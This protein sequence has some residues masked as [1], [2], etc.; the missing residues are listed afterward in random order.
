[1]KI[2]LVVTDSRGK[3][4]VFVSDTLRAYSLEEA[5]GLAENGKLEGI[6]PV[7]RASGVYLRTKPSV[8]AKEHLE[9]LS[10]SAHKLYASADNL[11]SVLSTDAFRTYWRLYQDSLDKAEPN[12]VID[13]H[14]RVA[15]ETVKEKL[16]PHRNL[17]FEAAKKF[18][19][20]SYLLGAIIID[21]IARL[22]PFEEIAD[23]LAVN[24]IGANT[25]AG[26]AQVKMDTARGLIKDGY[27]NPDPH[28][29]KL[30]AA[31]IKK[32]S[33]SYLYDYVKEPEHSIFFAAARMRSLIDE[34]KRSID[35]SQ[36]PEIIATLYHLP[37]IDPHAHPQPNDRGL[38]IANEFY[39]LAR[40][41]LLP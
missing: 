28:D 16:Q 9:R 1:M 22:N 30:S 8:P 37:Y 5:T 7:R 3:N 19:V 27:Y 18:N 41:W 25:S 21:E 26:I 10:I 2:I 38:Q 17:I 39:K 33:R 31:N 14:P 11:N 12:I 6:Y 20:D 35:I 13:G 34:W 40:E 36:R 32:V 15:K 4:L 29:S 24:F 23:R